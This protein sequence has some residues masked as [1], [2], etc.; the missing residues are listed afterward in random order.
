MLYCPLPR[1]LSLRCILA[2]RNPFPV[3]TTVD[4]PVRLAPSYT[5]ADTKSV[6]ISNGER[7]TSDDDDVAIGRLVCLTLTYEQTL[8]KI[9]FLFASL[10]PSHIT[11]LTPSS[12]KASS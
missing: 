6:A 10:P 7:D 2:V 12:A 5:A 11:T 3:I 9:A 8:I 4:Q 1:L